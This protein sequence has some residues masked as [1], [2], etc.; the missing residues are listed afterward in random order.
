MKLLLIEP[1]I[2]GYALM[3][4]MSLAILKSFINNKTK[5]QAKI[6][7]LIFH[8]KD[9]KEYLKEKLTKE[10]PDLIGMSILSFNYAQAI[11]IADFIKENFN[12]KIIFGGVHV[13]LM[14]EETLQNK[15]VDMI[16][17][18]EG[19][20]TLKSLLDK[21]INP[22]K[23]KGLW[24]KKRAVTMRHG[25]NEKR[26]SGDRWPRDFTYINGCPGAEKIG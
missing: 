22:E 10:K 2:E 12:V 1:N 5:H 18:G 15:S 24:Y 7:D 9:W 19:E 4:T 3:P 8:K 17:T 14:P 16:C 25:P 23:I 21:K 26:P 13:I 20:L 6:I 11:K